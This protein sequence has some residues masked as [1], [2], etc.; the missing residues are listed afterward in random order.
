MR[1][2]REKSAK[3][4]QFSH[5]C[6]SL[7]VGK[8]VRLELLNIAI[9]ASSSRRVKTF[10]HIVEILLVQEFGAHKLVDGIP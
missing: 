5:R 9:T 1:I 6:G 7:F 2:S 4:S 3:K 8:E 10:P